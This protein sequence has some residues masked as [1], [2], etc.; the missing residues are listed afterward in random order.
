LLAR[1][2]RFL[3]GQPIHNRLAHHERLPKVLALPVFASDALSSVAYATEAILLI[4]VLYGAQAIQNQIPITLAI[5][6]LIAIVVTSYRQTIMAYPQGGGSYVV[7]SENLGSI[8][9]LTAGSAL[10]I[11]YVLTVA[12]SVSA[13]VAAIVSAFPAVHEYLVQI[14]VVATLFIGWLN[15]RGMRESG[16]VFALPTYSFVFAI[17]TMIVI[18]ILRNFGSADHMPQVIGQPNMIGSEANWPFLFI[19]LRSFAAGCTALT[20]VEAVSDG[21]PA[22][23]PPEAKNAA[24]TLTWMGCILIVMFLGIGYLA[25]HLPKLL[26]YPTVD[27]E[28]RTLV[29]QIAAHTFGAGSPFFYFIQIATAAILILA[30]NTAFAD[31]PRLANWMARDGYLPRQ[32]A[33]QGDRLVF[34]NGII[35]LALAACALIWYFHG[36][37][38]HLLPLYAVGVFLAFTMSQAGM[39]ARW[40]KLRNPGWQRR[41]TINGIGAVSTGVVMLVILVTKFAE[42]AWIVAILLVI[43]FAIF[44]FIRRHYDTSAKQLEIPASYEPRKAVNTVLLL[45]PRIHRGILPSIEYARSI[46]LDAR[47]VH[48]AINETQIPAISKEWKK[49]GMGMPLV[50]LESPFRSLLH[51]VLEYIDEAISEHPDHVVTVIVPEYVPAKWWHSLLHENVALQLKLALATRPNVVVTNVRYFLDERQT[52]DG[53]T[54]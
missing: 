24:T 45:V 22:F 2:R 5:C 50:I 17:L 1:A 37:L 13:G 44:R 27:P 46:G 11:D 51:P 16:A 30:A 33:R 42:G 35:V 43:Q 25:E 10:L 26:V 23:R 21:V 12:V 20:G 15:L 36:Q 6:V 54:S 28:Y 19:V 40:L 39:F 41:A 29:S 48:V 9:G 4:L 14:G 32:F 31:F 53:I 7:A 49:Y 34:Q 18:G 8:A 38:D 3:F 47:A 52:K